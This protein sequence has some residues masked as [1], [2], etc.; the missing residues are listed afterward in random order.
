MPTN[1]VH[2]SIHFSAMAKRVENNFT[3]KYIVTNSIVAMPNAPLTLS[4]LYILE[5]FNVMSPRAIVGIFSE[6]GT[7]FLKYFHQFRMLSEAFS[8]I[9][10]K[11]G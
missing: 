6:N 5:F 4:R 7:Q 2:R 11:S 3:A 8:G 10:P 1:A 9:A